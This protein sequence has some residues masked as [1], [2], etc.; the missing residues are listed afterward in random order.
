[1]KNQ[2]PQTQPYPKEIMELNS[3]KGFI[4]FFWSMLSDY[5]TNQKAYEATERN[6]QRYFGSSRFKNYESFKKTIQYLKKQKAPPF[7]KSRS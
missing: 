3:H 5:D 1:M 2:L 6:H 4:Q 7:G